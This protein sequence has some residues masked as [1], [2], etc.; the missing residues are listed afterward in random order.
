MRPDQ[1]TFMPPEEFDMRRDHWAELLPEARCLELRA[2]NRI[3]ELDK[4]AEQA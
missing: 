2:L 4:V 3:N 1:K